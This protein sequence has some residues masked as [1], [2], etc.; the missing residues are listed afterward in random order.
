MLDTDECLPTSIHQYIYTASKF[1]YYTPTQICP[2]HMT[3]IADQT[4]KPVLSNGHSSTYK[5]TTCN[6]VGINYAFFIHLTNSLGQL[7]WPSQMAACSV[8]P[9]LHSRAAFS[10]YVTLHCNIPSSKQKCHTI[11]IWTSYIHRTL[12]PSDLPPQTAVN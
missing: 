6:T 8:Q 1:V 11:G 10:L 5:F 4:Q 3:E 2:S 7:H 9:F 12:R